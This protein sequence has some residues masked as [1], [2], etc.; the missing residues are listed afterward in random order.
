LAKI[1][2]VNGF[3]LGPTVSV[4]RYFLLKCALAK[5]KGVN[6]FELGPTVSEA[7]ARLIETQPVPMR[8]M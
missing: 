3:E 7:N 2:G 8:L 6:G 5:M 4:Q 1:K